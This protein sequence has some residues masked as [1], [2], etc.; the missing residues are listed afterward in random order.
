[1]S[2][3]LYQAD[4]A[5]GGRTFDQDPMFFLDLND[6]QVRELDPETGLYPFMVSASDETSDLSAVY[7]LLKR[8]PSLVNS[9]FAHNSNRKRKI[10]S[11]REKGSED[12]IRRCSLTWTWF[13]WNPVLHI[14]EI[15]GSVLK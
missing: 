5:S 14:Y 1:M 12:L 6:E 7:R 3:V 15:H 13:P 4:L 11:V 10:R 2:R 8:N 9:G